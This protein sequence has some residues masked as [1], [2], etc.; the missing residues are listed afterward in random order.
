MKKRILA[1]VLSVLMAASLTGCSGELS[2]DYITITKYE[3]LEVAQVEKTEVSDETVEST[4]SSKLYAAT[5]VEEVKDRAAEDGDT[6][7]IDYVGTVDGAA[8][9][10]GT[11]EAQN[12]VLGSGQYIGA[13]GE[14]KGFEEQV[15]GHMPGEDFDITVQFPDEYKNNPDMA[16]KVAVFHIT[17]NYISVSNT[18]ELTDE[19]V[20]EN[21]KESE[22][23]E[24]YKAEVKKQLEEESYQSALQDEVMEAFMDSVEVKELPEEDVNE[25]L[26]SINGYYKSLATA[27]GMEFDAFL[28]TYMGM[29]EESYNEKAQEAAELAIKR[30][31]ACE[32]LAEKKRLTPT[33]EEYE[34]GIAEYAEQSGTDADTLK[35]QVGE[36]VLKR[37]VL[38]DKVAE[39]LADKCV[40]VEASESEE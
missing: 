31:L 20:K 9:D 30:R 10:G 38:Q 3:G 40:Q 11:A 24:E 23:V 8:F 17:L 33:D 19:W 1:A 4:I 12:L 15:V 29:T 27:Y 37:T 14:H 13:N 28:T 6:V 18:P 7:N 32:L 5:T 36:D 34:K 26:D 35:A 21:S 25:Q 16:K 22:T 2:N 39:Y